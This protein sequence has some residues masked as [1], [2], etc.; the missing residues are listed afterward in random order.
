MSEVPSDDIRVDSG[1][2]EENGP[3]GIFP[4]WGVLYVTVLA[5]TLLLILILYW[6]TVSLDFHA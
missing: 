3:I 5:H 1:E 4:S 6:F 2:D